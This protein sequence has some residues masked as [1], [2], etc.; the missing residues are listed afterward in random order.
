VV[1]Q[2]V[3]AMVD[4]DTELISIYFGSDS[5]EEEAQRIQGLVGKAHPNCD[6]ELQMGGQPIYYYIIS[7]E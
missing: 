3:D 1:L 7:A 6:V 4:E 5:S 2:L